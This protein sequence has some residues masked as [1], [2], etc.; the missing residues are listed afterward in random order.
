MRGP[1]GD[2]L[3]IVAITP[4]PCLEQRVEGAGSGQPVRAEAA[5]RRGRDQGVRRAR[6]LARRA[7]STLRPPMDF[8]RARNPCVR[9]RLTTEGWYVRF[10]SGCLG[11]KKPYI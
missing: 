4:A 1:R 7:E 2:Q 9:L 5:Q 6:P 8:M 10:M 3:H 11:V